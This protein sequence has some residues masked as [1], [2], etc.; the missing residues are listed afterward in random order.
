MFA[1]ANLVSEV[2]FHASQLYSRNVVNFILNL[3]SKE[4]AM[5]VAA[6]GA[7]ED[8]IL[9]ESRVAAGG[10]VTHPRVQRALTA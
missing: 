3:T 6:E 2:A 1:P 5:K 8:E 9:R 10:A 4:G 7:Q